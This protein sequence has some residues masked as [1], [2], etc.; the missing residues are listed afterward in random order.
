MI[1]FLTSSL[2]LLFWF[3]LFCVQ[4]RCLSFNISR[5]Q[6]GKWNGTMLL[7][8]SPYIFTKNKSKQTYTLSHSHCLPLQIQYQNMWPTIGLNIIYFKDEKGSG[9]AKMQH[10]PY[11]KIGQRFLYDSRKSID[12][13]VWGKSFSFQDDNFHML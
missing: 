10:E 7:L 13:T 6:E 4:T 11:S 2:L 9:K 5:F 3:S 1:L 8:S 12:N